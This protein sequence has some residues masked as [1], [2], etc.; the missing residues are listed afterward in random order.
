MVVSY[1][2]I[3]CLHLLHWLVSI[4]ILEQTSFLFLNL[5]YLW[6]LKSVLLKSIGKFKAQTFDELL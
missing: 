3:L 1:Y 5:P 4:L 6:L 2:T